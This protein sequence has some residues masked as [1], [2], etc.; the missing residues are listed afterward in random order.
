MVSWSE[1]HLFCKE[2]GYIYIYIYTNI[3]SEHQGNAT[4]VTMNDSSVPSSFFV[5][6]ALNAFF[7]RRNWMLLSLVQENSLAD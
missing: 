5:L 7:L 6:H 1:Y 3:Q 2:K 4:Y